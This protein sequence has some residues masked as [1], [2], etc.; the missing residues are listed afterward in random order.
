[1]TEGA[2]LRDL[3]LSAVVLLL[4]I[5]LWPMIGIS[6]VVGH[7][8]EK[9]LTAQKDHHQVMMGLKD[10]AID[11]WRGMWRTCFDA[12][13]P[14]RTID[15]ESLRPVS[16]TQFRH[17]WHCDRY[18]TDEELVAIEREMMRRR[19]TGSNKCISSL[20]Y[21]ARVRSARS[22]LAKLLTRDGRVEMGI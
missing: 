16:C 4:H 14:A 10:G 18:V 13:R 12:A 20:V 5:W 6:W 2:R 3:R 9:R 8:Y 15:P 22:L 21:A 17:G 19:G 1:M 11:D 7:H